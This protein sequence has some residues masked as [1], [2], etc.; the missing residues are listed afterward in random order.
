MT[1]RKR[2][3]RADEI[4]SMEFLIHHKSY[5]KPISLAKKIGVFF[6][7]L[8]VLL[9]SIRIAKSMRPRRIALATFR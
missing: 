7:T 9:L 8:F 3:Q 2:V 6:Y 4:N 1:Y 5:G